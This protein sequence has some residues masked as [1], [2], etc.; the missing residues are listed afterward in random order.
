MLYN[1]ISWCIFGLIAGVIAKF[2]MPGRDP[3]GCIVTILL[4]IAGAVVGGYIAEFFNL[5]GKSGQVGDKGFLI[6]LAFAVI[7]AILLL[8]VYRMIAGKRQ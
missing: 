4:G 3:G 7:G 6:R 2:L 1:L 8:V 5:A